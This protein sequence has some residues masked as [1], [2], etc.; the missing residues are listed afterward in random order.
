LGLNCIYG[1]QYDP[2]MSDCSNISLAGRSI[3]AKAAVSVMN[4]ST[5]TLNSS[6]ENAFLTDNMIRVLSDR[7]RYSSGGLHN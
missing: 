6:V 2:I 1:D 3:S 7:Q 5:T 4:C